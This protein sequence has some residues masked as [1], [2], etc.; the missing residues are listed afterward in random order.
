MPHKLRQYELYVTNEPATYNEFD[1]GINTNPSNE[2]LEKNELRDA[3]NMHYQQGSLVKRPGAKLLTTL[4]SDSD[5]FKIQGVSLFTYKLTY[6]V[7]AANG[8]LYYGIYSPNSTVNI[9]KLDI[10]IRGKNNTKLYDPE[11]MI[12]D[13][14]IVY[15]LDNATLNSEHSGFVFNKNNIKPILFEDIK[16]NKNKISKDQYLI[17]NQE[18]Y[19]ALKDVTIKINLP[20]QFHPTLEVWKTYDYLVAEQKYDS[21]LSDEQNLSKY[22]VFLKANFL[23]KKIDG[24]SITEA[25]KLNII[26]WTENNNVYS[27]GQIVRYGFSDINSLPIAVKVEYDNLVAQLIIKN[28]QLTGL[29]GLLLS[30]ENSLKLYVDAIVNNLP[31]GQSYDFKNDA[32]YNLLLNQIAQTKV[33]IGNKS[34]INEEDKVVARNGILGEIQTLEDKIE[35]FIFLNYYE[36]LN[37]HV[38]KELPNFQLEFVRTESV[39][40]LI[41]QNQNKIEGATYNNRLYLATGTRFVEVYLDN[42]GELQ[43]QVVHA[44]LPN[45]SE[46]LL[47]GPNYYSPY[48]EYARATLFNQ[49]ITRIDLILTTAIKEKDFI[50]QGTR[51]TEQGGILTYTPE[52]IE[53]EKNKYILEPIMT[54][55]NVEKPDDYFF[56]WE[57]KVDNVWKTVVAFKDNQFAGLSYFNLKVEDADLYQYRVT[58]A[59]AFKFD[60]DLESNTSTLV[61]ENIVRDND[62]QDTDWVIDKAAADYYGS[63]STIL[64]VPPGIDETFKMIHS[65]KKI[66][67]DGNKFLLYDDAYNSGMWFKTVIDTPGY[68]TQRGMLSFK[69]NKNEGVIKVVQFAGAIIVFANSPEIGGS[70]HLIE[71]KGDDFEGD[72]YY[73]P[74][75]RRTLNESISCDNPDTVQT[76]EGLLFFKYFD[77]VYYIRANE[78]SD[79]VITIYS[80]NDRIKKE[81]PEVKI[82]W[83]DNSCISEITQDYYAIIWKEKYIIENDQL[84]LVHPAIK[85]K[86]YYKVNYKIAEKFFMPW[87]RDESEYFNV[88]HIVYIEGYPVYL[89][90]NVF[91]TFNSNV[92]TDFDKIYECK[93]HFRAVDLNYPKFYKLL[94][95]AL[96]YYHRNQNSNIDFDIE[97]RNEAGHVLLS[98]NKPSVQD[99][100][101]LKIGDVFNKD[102]VRLDN[103]IVDSKLFNSEYRFP[104]L[105]A[106]TIVRSKNDKDFTFASITYTYNTVDIPD[107]NPYD[108]YVNIIRKKEN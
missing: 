93:L 61:L 3:L 73:S 8:Q 52:F 76:A 44:Y 24:T 40:E 11:N 85:V 67:G 53:V 77:T 64:F 37:T 101:N 29:N 72:T 31:F 18:I 60:V 105:L 10:K 55:A 39:E 48:P 1:G 5:L 12:A 25:Q 19:K 75:R 51:T 45:I 43:A 97:I 92:F 102:R 80:A 62:T 20:T 88:D 26:N 16:L 41:F 104:L 95:S 100:K 2:H 28:N 98:S 65:C 69:T 89:Y 9:R 78:I 71:G 27:E 33:Q 15:N 38:V 49:A 7:I 74:Y 17:Y 82:P 30:L 22:N 46:N 87:L 107:T 14:P 4:N 103:T 50:Q 56:K 58:F 91:V 36:C 34:F 32:Q 99:I 21:S 63:G 86:L 57:K 106:D 47:I 84:T 83:G 96:V 13:L 81:S 66:I 108:L 54:F 6:I 94:S 35:G 23:W 79:D 59:K 90:N 68:F 70:I 42:K